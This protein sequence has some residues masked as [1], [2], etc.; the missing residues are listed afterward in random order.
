MNKSKASEQEETVMGY[1]DKQKALDTIKHLDGRDICYQHSV[2]TSFINRAKRTLQI[3]K[4]DEKITNIKEAIQV[5]EEWFVDYKK[6]K[7]NQKNFAYLPL[8]TINAFR[9]IAKKYEVLDEAFYLAYKKEKGDYRGLRTEKVDNGEITWDIERN[10][11]LAK[12]IRKI[13]E[14]HVQWYETDVGEFRGLPTKEHTQCILLGYSPEPLKLRKMISKLRETFGSLENSNITEMEVE[15]EKKMS[16]RKH[17]ESADQSSSEEESSKKQ[18][19][20]ESGLGFKD[21]EKALRSI[22][23]LEERDVNYQYNAIKGL[24][25]RAKRVISCTKDEHKITHMKEAIE[26]FEKWITD[27]NVNGRSKDNF[28]YLSLDV[29]H[30]YKPLA[31]N[32]GI[33]DNGFLE[34]YEQQ[35]GDYKKLRSVK[36]PNSNITWDI[37]R[38]RKLRTIVDYIN[39][40]DV[41]WFVSEGDLTGL[42]TK[43]HVECIMWAFSYESSKVKKLLPKLKEKLNIS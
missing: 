24:V 3:T 23:S 28:G 20:E 34:F 42:P 9:P 6:N 16:K 12:L 21:K 4:D 43:E 2:I 18:K 37:E 13:K 33:E 38:N 7:G 36:L 1:K 31:E 27:Y 10:R 5:F 14:D 17:D 26:V 19:Q 39:K 32:Y 25:G 22:K 11:R 40:N 30:G 41:K 15:D 29:V 35:E 8:E